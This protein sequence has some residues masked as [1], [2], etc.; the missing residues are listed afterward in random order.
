MPP[1]LERAP[2]LPPAA[3]PPLIHVPQGTPD[4]TAAVNAVCE[5]ASSLVAAKQEVEQLQ[6]EKQAALE[7]AA[8]HQV[9]S[10]R[11]RA[12]IERLRGERDEQAA[13]Q[14]SLE[15]DL[16]QRKRKLEAMQV[17]WVGWLGGLAGWAGWVHSQPSASNPV[18]QATLCGKQP[19]ARDATEHKEQPCVC[20]PTPL[21]C[22]M[23]PPLPYCPPPLPASERPASGQRG[24]AARRGRQGGG[25]QPAGSTE[26]HVQAAAGRRT[27]QG[28]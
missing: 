11:R 1:A 10:E 21:L 8:A 27:Q 15:A 9:A 14:L 5:L 2:T 22:S 28:G 17:G 13:R 18:Q 25:R 26:G 6:R 12:T 16:A 24:S 7:Q 23:L 19:C 20:C 3:L 4:G